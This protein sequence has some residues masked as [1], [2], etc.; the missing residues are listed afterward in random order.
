MVSEGRA[1][2]RPHGCSV[3]AHTRSD[4]AGDPQPDA[5]EG[6]RRSSAHDSRPMQSHSTDRGTAK[7]PEP[8][9]LR[10]AP[11]DRDCW[12]PSDDLDWSARNC[13][14]SRRPADQPAAP[15]SLSHPLCILDRGPTL[16]ER[17]HVEGE[18]PMQV[19][20]AFD[21]LQTAVNASPDQL[22][23]ARERR[24]KF[25][26]AFASEGD[27]TG[28]FL[29]GSL[30]RR[31]MIDPI[32]DVDFVV[33]YEASE[34]PD[35][36]GPGSSAE[37]ALSYVGG[38]V[39]RLLGSTNGTVAKLVRLARVRNHVV[40]C[41]VDDPDDDDP[42]HVDLLPAIRQD[43]GRLLIPEK[44][45]MNWIE[46]DPEDL[47]ER[48]AKRQ[49]AWDQFVPMVRLLKRWNRDV[50]KTEMKSLTTEVLAY[51]CIPDWYTTDDT[52][53][54]PD[55]LSA[56]FTAAVVAIDEPICDPAGICGEIQPD[57][58]TGAVK[59]VLQ[60]ASDAA[61]LALAAQRRGDD[62]PA[63]CQWRKVFGDLMPAPPEGCG[64]PATGV[65]AAATAAVTPRLIRNTPQG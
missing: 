8:A 43:N 9:A 53:Y 51:S 58:D 12:V 35:W 32:H 50:A 46:A 1:A 55:A 62:H 27:T 23:T 59:R 13:M 5:P 48:V 14:G 25:T 21:R 52:D 11:T 36:G 56:F 29:S 28:S 60:D 16:D 31:T 49:T 15:A 19:S 33:L 20:T 57:L 3:L 63:I 37:D 4:D 26:E 40:K 7:A 17:G 42:F 45:S 47:I 61:Y 64:K 30:A 39:N 44:L 6:A 22:A 24:D 2:P 34:H 38:R 54:R 41:F 18:I 65:G 10:P